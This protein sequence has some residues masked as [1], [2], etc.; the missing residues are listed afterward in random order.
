MNNWIVIP[1]LWVK[2]RRKN[3]AWLEED[4]ENSLLPKKP[5]NN[6]VEK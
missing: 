2:E 1:S 6:I 4:V 3:V 5:V